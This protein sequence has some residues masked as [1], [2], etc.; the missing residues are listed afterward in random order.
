MDTPMLAPHAYQG[1]HK[2]KGLDTKLSTLM[3]L[4]IASMLA[5]RVMH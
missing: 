4:A 1:L 2:K 5:L 3:L